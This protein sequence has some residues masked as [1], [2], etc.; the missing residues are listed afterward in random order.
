[1]IKDVS[2]LINIVM[3]SFYS[4]AYNQI[5]VVCCVPL[6]TQT[7]KSKILIKIFVKFRKIMM[8]YQNKLVGRSFF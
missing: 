6:V 1:M 2:F 3:Q 5:S 7:I 8:K 4:K